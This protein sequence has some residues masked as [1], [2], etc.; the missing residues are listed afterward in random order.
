ML[1]KKNPK[2]DVRRN[3]SMYF[4]VGLVTMLILVNYAI[5][6][7]SFDK[8]IVDTGIV[9]MNQEFD[10]DIPIVDEIKTLPPPPASVP[11]PDITIVEDDKVVTE[12]VIE[13]TDTDQ[14]EEIYVEDIVVDEV[15]EDVPVAFVVIENVPEYPGCESGDN[16]TKK[17]CMSDKINQFVRKEFNTEL[18][19]ELGLTG[20]QTIN[21][22]FNIDKSGDVVD[23]QT[24]APH[25]RLSK[26]AERVMKLL[27][28]MKPG[29]QRG[30]PVTVQYGFPII[31]KVID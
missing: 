6:Y 30:N 21:V 22:I 14:D 16:E 8:E 23:I 18:S 31:F 20:Q 15:D 2:I 13:A 5:N 4:A 29:R 27:P 3:S 1:P 28:K 26:E 11:T 19:S 9:E 10:L 12:T 7:K 17:K 24:R 25:P